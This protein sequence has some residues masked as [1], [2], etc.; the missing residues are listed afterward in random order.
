M[1]SKNPVQ[2]LKEIVCET[3]GRISDFTKSAAAFTRN[4]KLNAET[5]L[6]VTLNM[7]GNSLNAELLEAFPDIDTRMTASAYE[8]AKD[9]LRPDVFKHIFKE[10]NKT[11]TP[12]LYE[13]KYRL[14]AIDGSDFT[15]PFN[16][17]SANRIHSA[18]EKDICQVH[19]NI[20]YDIQNRTYE[21]CV[22][23]PK[24]KSDE[25]KAAISMLKDLDADGEPYIVVMDRGYASFNMFET[26]NRLDRCN[27]VI[28]TKAGN[29]A[30]NEIKA[31][32]DAEIDTDIV[33][34]VTTSNHFYMQHRKDMPSLHCIQHPKKRHKET[35]SE[36]TDCTAWDFGQFCAIKCRVCKFKISDDTYEVIV[37]NLSREEF[38]IEKI[39]ELY[40]L[41]WDIET[42]FRELKYALGG[43][44]FH[45]KK[46]DFVAMEI[47]AH[48]VMF[49]VVSRNIAQVS[50]PQVNHKH[51]YAVDFKMAC[52]I[53]R[54]Y[55]AIRSFSD[56][57]RLLAEILSYINPVRPGRKDK[58]N[59]K[60]KSAVWFV[61]RVA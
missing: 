22:L 35:Y 3:A 45:S 55:F 41:R 33:F 16:P 59:M 21:D 28:R 48:L 57:R 36:N 17:N 27:Y 6:S 61:Y 29:T 43:M 2:V 14:F 12:S 9:K 31:L 58:R 32:P 5:M 53:V 7:Q 15:T 38:P 60:P 50:V 49:N 23:Q 56:H 19:A 11:A 54:K 13:G 10:Y 44:H 1:E 52:L 24:S 37:T 47:Y 34:D 8:Q 4:R 30:I 25:R 42:S 46:D 51:R 18:G 40:H 20:L 39:K 26:C